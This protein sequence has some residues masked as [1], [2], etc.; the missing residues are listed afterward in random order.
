MAKPSRS[1]KKGKKWA[2][3]PEDIERARRVAAGLEASFTLP[4]PPGALA[5]APFLD[6]IR[7]L[8][9]AGIKGMTDHLAATSP[10][11]RVPTLAALRELADAD[12][13]PALLVHAR[14]L[15]WPP[16]DLAALGETIRA[17]EPEAE[18]PA[19]LEPGALERTSRAAARLAGELNARGAGEVCDLI[20]DLPPR[21]R[22]LALR[23][24]AGEGGRP[25]NLLAL[26]RAMAE[27]GVPPPVLL[28]DALAS[29]ETKEAAGALAGLAG[30]TADKETGSR[31]RKALYRLRSRGVAV[32]EKE[33][34][35]PAPP[36]APGIDF[37]VARISAVDGLGRMMVWIARSLQPRGRFVVEAML[38]RGHGVEDFATAD[39]G[40]KELRE[41]FARIGD[42]ASHL[43]T[44]EIP[45]GYAVWLLQ[46]AQREAEREGQSLPSGFTR[47]KLFLEPL[48]DPA[49]FPPPAP[50]EGHP[51][52]RLVQA[53]GPGEPRLEPR[54][55]FEQKAFW[56]WLI[57]ERKILPHLR[58]LVDSL[59]SK[60]VVEEAQRRARLERIVS[61]AAGA[62][63]ADGALRGR[64]EEA[65]EDNAFF[66]HA[67]G[68]A[69]LARE[70]LAL[71]GEMGAGGEPPAFFREMVHLTLS[72]LLDRLARQSQA[73]GKKEEERGA[74]G[75]QGSIIATP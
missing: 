33:K 62:L 35:A 59:Q 60:V 52:R 40:A 75:G 15:R 18:L 39:L 13:V 64:M 54:E 12:A 28:I 16:G 42:P 49:A 34:E 38:R 51:V 61:D 14:A 70:C 32:E 63:F 56:S 72:V 74:P 26:A 57:E 17:L 73:A 30:G 21:L 48:A 1:R 19:E 58:T 23:E 2:A 43:A 67:S 8:G 36:S 68:Q 9:E 41:V 37:A 50:G 29:L 66:F 31:L 65:L 6:E 46:R 4:P 22:E 20:R 25:S 5:P 27:R 7:E 24:A 53:P 55:L 3:S 10:Q 45:L 44:C 69:A 71:A 47:A 11:G